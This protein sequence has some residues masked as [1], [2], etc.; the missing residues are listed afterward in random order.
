M[1]RSF[2]D[3][4]E[5]MMQ[6][7]HY[8]VRRMSIVPC[9]VTIYYTRLVIYDCASQWTDETWSILIILLI[10]YDYESA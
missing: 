7:L 6:V 3:A 1:M 4:V 10:V 9:L 5:G 8:L 2:A